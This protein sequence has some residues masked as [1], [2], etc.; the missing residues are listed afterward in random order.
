MPTTSVQNA[1]LAAHQFSQNN[2]S[3]SVPISVSPLT[4]DWTS[5]ATRN[6]SDGTNAWTTPGGDFSS[7]PSVTSTITPSTGWDHWY[8]TQLVQGWING[9]ISDHGLLL[10]EPTENIGN[11]LYFDDKEYS[12]SSDWL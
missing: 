2:T 6:T 5:G 3:T 8:P 7:S 12:N 1:D 9:S 10:K 11:V 4:R